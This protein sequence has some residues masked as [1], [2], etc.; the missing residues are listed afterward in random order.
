MGKLEKCVLLFVVVLDVEG[1]REAE[2]KLET[3]CSSGNVLA[4]TYFL[5]LSL[6]I[7]FLPFYRI[8]ILSFFPELFMFLLYFSSSRIQP[9]DVI[10]ELRRTCFRALIRFKLSLPLQSTSPTFPNQASLNAELTSATNPTACPPSTASMICSSIV[11][12]CLRSSYP[13]QFPAVISVAAYA[14]FL[15][16][17]VLPT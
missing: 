15:K 14:A 6:D 16:V 7:Q 3:W 1:K 8:I 10:F 12:S 5:L 4:L 17:Y 13:S 2:L 11:G 9:R